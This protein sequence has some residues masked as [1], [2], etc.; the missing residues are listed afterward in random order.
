MEGTSRNV[1]TADDLDST[2]LRHQVQRYF[3]ELQQDSLM[4]DTPLN[5]EFLGMKRKPAGTAASSSSAAQNKPLDSV[6]P[7]RIRFDNTGDLS[8]LTGDYSGIFAGRRQVHDSIS[9][10]RLDISAAQSERQ[11]AEKQAKIIDLQQK[12]VQLEMQLS[13][14]ESSKE[15]LKMTT[16]EV[17]E[18]CTKKL[19]VYE[20]KIEDLKAELKQVQLK[21]DRL[22][23]ENH[24]KAELVQELK[25]AVSEEKLAFGRELAD[26]EQLTVELQTTYEEQIR[27][28]RNMLHEAEKQIF[29]FE[30]DAEEARSQLRDAQAQVLPPSCDHQSVIDQQSQV[31]EEMQNALFAQ[32]TTF[33]QSQEAKLA[34]IPQVFK[35]FHF[36]CAHFLIVLLKTRWKRK[37]FNC[38]RLTNSSERRPLTNCC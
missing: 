23:S 25:L 7:K 3:S 28:L 27:E 6:L 15:Q 8:S 30:T 29:K 33:S 31:I 12:V 4:T 19:K 2:V 9:T 22:T 32:R 20:D 26:N 17:K 18:A 21:V 14:S 11:M 37:L 34:R 10:S 1:S 36:P 24:Q 38:S 16:K 35:H 13:E 5:M